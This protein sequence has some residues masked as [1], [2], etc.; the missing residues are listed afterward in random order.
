M[1][2]QTETS[3]VKVF[4]YQQVFESHMNTQQFNF[5]MNTPV[6]LKCLGVMV[7]FCLLTACGGG[8]GGSASSGTQMTVSAIA[9]PPPPITLK[10]AESGDNLSITPSFNFGTGIIS[11]TGSAT[12]IQATS[13]SVISITKPTQTTTFKLTVQYQ[14]QDPSTIKPSNLSGSIET[15]AVYTVTPTTTPPPKPT[16]GITAT[17]NGVT[18]STSITINSGDPV[19]LKPTFSFDSGY[20]TSAEIIRPKRASD[21]GY[22]PSALPPETVSVQVNNLTTITDYPLETTRY[23]LKVYYENISH[24]IQTPVNKYIEVVV[25]SSPGKVSIGGNLTSPRSDHA[26]ANIPSSPLVLASGGTS[27]GT[28]VLKTSEVYDP[29]NNKWQLTGDMKIARRGHIATALQNGKILVTGGYDGKNALATAEIYD[30]SNGTW[31]ATTGTMSLARRFHTATLLA[32]GRVLIAGGTVVGNG[33]PKITELYDPI[34]GKFYIGTSL[35]EPRLGHTATLLNE[36]KVLI[37]GN[38]T[39]GLDGKKTIL[40]NYLPCTPQ[41]CTDSSTIIPV[42]SMLNSRSNHTATSLTDGNILVTGGFGNGIDKAEIFNI[43]LRSWSATA[44]GMN[45]RHALHTATLLQ[46]GSVLIVGGYDG[47]TPTN[48]IEIYKDSSFQT[49]KTLNTNRAMHTSALLPN[50][51]VLIF[52]TYC[53][54]SSASCTTSNTSEVWLKPVP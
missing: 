47:S 11:Q 31:T 43:T 1:G 54:S 2:H 27:D 44:S 33:D 35:P 46:D 3:D 34:D 48:I 25:V 50:G 42:G 52:G 15:T 5:K 53:P 17:N 6:W 16:L 28:T 30:P 10:V 37:T 14:Y 29:V 23:T 19:V 39:S 40:F 22:S 21:P 26:S 49:G 7:F 13:G 4:L 36:G 18:S 9:P 24:D 38:S 45:G 20:I 41:P 8:G 32:D 12:Q 51:N